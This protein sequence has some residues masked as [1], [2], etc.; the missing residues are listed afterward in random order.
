MCGFWLKEAEIRQPSCLGDEVTGGVI[1]SRHVAERRAVRCSL[2]SQQARVEGVEDCAEEFSVAAVGDRVHM[3]LYDCGR[4]A[5][6]WSGDVT[7]VR[8]EGVLYPSRQMGTDGSEQGFVPGGSRGGGFRRPGPTATWGVG[9]HVGW[10]EQPQYDA[11]W[12]E[13]VNDAAE[14][15][16]VA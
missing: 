6:G 4:D 12:F 14:R 5:S 8:R 2:K 11:N 7:A 9:R 10:S 16:S 1:E 3:D 15:T 13:A